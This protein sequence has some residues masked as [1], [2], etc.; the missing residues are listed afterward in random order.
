MVMDYF[1]AGSEI[2]S[3]MDLFSSLFF[4]VLY[5][6]CIYIFIAGPPYG[7]DMGWLLTLVH[8]SSAVHPMLST[9]YDCRNLLVTL[10]F[11]YPSRDRKHG[12]QPNFLL[13]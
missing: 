9:E 7:P 13:Q 2:L 1:V 3:L 5:L 4:V 12:L 10:I 6:L 8:L 11:C